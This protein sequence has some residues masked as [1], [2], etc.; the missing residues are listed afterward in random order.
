ME[1]S[2]HKPPTTAQFHKFT[3]EGVEPKKGQGRK[4]KQLLKMMPVRSKESLYHSKGDPKV[5][6]NTIL[7]RV[8]EDGMLN[9]S[10]P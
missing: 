1:P 4:R 6:L 10:S 7:F 2:G 3:P 5:S 9:S 8:E